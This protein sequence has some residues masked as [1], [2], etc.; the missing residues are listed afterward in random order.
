M[1][2]LVIEIGFDPNITTIAGFLLSWHGLFTSVGILAGVQ[3]A[4]RM[5]RVVGYNED[6]TYT[7]ALVGVPAGIVGARRKLGGCFQCDLDP[8]DDVAGR[9]AVE[10]AG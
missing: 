9:D 6:D 2:I 10:R 1:P 5:A 4:L 8:T 3:L 7:L